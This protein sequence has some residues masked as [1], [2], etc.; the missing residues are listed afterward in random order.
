MAHAFLKTSGERRTADILTHT[1]VLQEK[2]AVSHPV[3]A[4]PYWVQASIGPG[5]GMG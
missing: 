4:A 3:G 5:I 2:A 1:L